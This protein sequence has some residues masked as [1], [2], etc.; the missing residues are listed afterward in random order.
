MAYLTQILK[1]NYIMAKYLIWLTTITV[2]I[3]IYRISQPHSLPS[4]AN[5]NS[6]IKKFKTH[7]M[8]LYQNKTKKIN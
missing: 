8:S 4:S 3:Y 2:Y 7:G 1:R 6:N 5:E